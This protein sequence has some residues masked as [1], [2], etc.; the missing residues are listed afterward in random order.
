MKDYKTEL[1]QLEANEKEAREAFDAAVAAAQRTK[2]AR[3]GKIAEAIA[4]QENRLAALTE[5]KA[6][7]ADQLAAAHLE[8]ETEYARELRGEI[9]AVEEDERDTAAVIAA[10]KGHDSAKAEAA[11]VDAAVAA[12]REAKKAAAALAE[13]AKQIPVEIDAEIDRLQQEQKRIADLL[14]MAQNHAKPNTKSP[15]ARQLLDLYEEAKAP[16]DVSGHLCGDDNV[17]KLRFIAGILNGIENT[18]AAELLKGGDA[19]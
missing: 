1:Q 16:I 2:D 14:S 12:Y 3:E 10:L 7:L 5:K 6:G 19:E 13:R 9:E 11:S 4:E 8:G 15:A 17:A 18:P